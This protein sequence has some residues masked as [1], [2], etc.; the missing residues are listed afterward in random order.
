[1]RREKCSGRGVGFE[2]STNSV[3]SIRIGGRVLAAWFVGWLVIMIAAAGVR[4]SPILCYAC[5]SGASKGTFV[6]IRPHEATFEKRKSREYAKI[7]AWSSPT[8]L[9]CSLG[10]FA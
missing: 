3:E 7:L 9:E 8:R 6:T 4:S 10:G 1:G 2:F 5:G